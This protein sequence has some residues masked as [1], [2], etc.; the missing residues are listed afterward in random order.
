M[1]YYSL[2]LDI[3]ATKMVG[4]IIINGKIIQL[5][6]RPTG[7]SN[8]KVKIIKN[9]E[10]MI[11]DLI[12]EK[13]VTNLRLK[14]IGIGLAGQI[15]QKDGV[16]IST[17]NFSSDFKNVKLAKILTDKFKVPVKLNND[18]KCFTLGETRFGVGRGYKNIVGLTFGTGIGGGIMINGQI[19]TGKNNTA[20]EFGHIKI[21]GH[22]L[23]TLPICGCGGKFC[24]E[25]VGSAKAWLKLSKK[26]NEKKA[27]EIISY[28]I[29]V[30]LCNIALILNPE[31]IILGGRLMKQENIL[32]KIKK[33]FFNQIKNYPWLKNTKI[34]ATKLGSQAILLGSLV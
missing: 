22:W 32:I 4:G 24:F 13:E 25:S 33:E 21:S 9:I 20:G 28:N 14:E 15:N 30:G 6:K 17:A 8:S 2:A 12:A 29:A 5:I 18:V 34:I 26:Y 16:V 31:L 1:S 27:D 3:G 10:Q 7:A 11:K 23:G 19:L